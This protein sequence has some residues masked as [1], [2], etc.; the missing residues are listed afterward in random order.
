M[1]TRLAALPQLGALL[2]IGAAALDRAMSAVV[3]R[4]GAGGVLYILAARGTEQKG[5]SL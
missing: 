5:Y 2:L 1:G 4:T 3:E